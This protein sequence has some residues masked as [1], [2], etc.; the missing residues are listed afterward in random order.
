M[1]TSVRLDAKT[2]RMVERLAR[3]KGLSKSEIIREAL[4]IA[5]NRETRIRK[6]DRPYDVVKHLIGSVEGLPPDLSVKTGKRFRQLLL[7]RKDSRRLPE[8]H[9][10]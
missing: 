3:E 4:S 6:A 2:E 5:A 1:P 7:E 8:K 10:R 9:S